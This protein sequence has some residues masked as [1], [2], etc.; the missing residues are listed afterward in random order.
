MK[1]NPK[2][3]SPAHLLKSIF[4]HAEYL[5]TGLNYASDELIVVNYHSTPAKFIDEFRSQI[6]FFQ[7]KFNIISPADLGNYFA[8]SIKSSKCMLLI[9]FD[10][11]LKNNLNAAKV[12]DEFSIKAFFFLVPAFLN[13]K[14]SQQKDY[15]LK[16]IR[17]QV[18]HV[19]DELEE[20]FSAMNDSDIQGLLAKGH[21]IGSHTYT[22]A[23]VASKSDEANSE[24]EVVNSK[25]ELEKRF[26]L[27]VSSFCSI[28]NTLESIGSKE[29]K[30]VEGHYQFHFT[31]I[32]GL[33]ATQKNPL[34]I[35]RRNI[36]CFWLKG[37]VYFALGKWD[38]KRWKAKEEEYLNL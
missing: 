31:T 33:N 19:I 28:N 2:I 24:K 7:R 6:R 5:F 20:D 34:F 11:G 36:E 27:P 25:S 37:A 16:H 10:D 30:I 1:Y 17:P 32:P 21:A 35:R 8:G 4:G 23:L 9:T 15:Y 14:S 18:N 13:C 22:H 26:G 3:H 29:K 38:L 12:L